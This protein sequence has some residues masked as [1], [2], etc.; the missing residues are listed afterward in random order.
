M[1]IS[2]EIDVLQEK[3]GYCALASSG[4]DLQLHVKDR[5]Q[6]KTIAR[7]RDC[8]PYNHKNRS[9]KFIFCFLSKNQGSYKKKNEATRFKFRCILQ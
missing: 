4:L 6:L 7:L 1:K 8:T 2:H 5:L 3:C 9:V